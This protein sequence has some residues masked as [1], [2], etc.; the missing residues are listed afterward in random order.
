M[1]SLTR[2][3]WARWSHRTLRLGHQRPH[4]ALPYV[5][6]P[7][8]EKA[9]VTQWRMTP[10]SVF[11][12]AALGPQQPPTEPSSQPKPP[13]GGAVSS[14]CQPTASRREENKGSTA[15]PWAPSFP[16]L[17]EGKRVPCID[18]L[19]SPVSSALCSSLSSLFSFFLADIGRVSLC[20]SQIPLVTHY[21]VTCSFWPPERPPGPP[22]LTPP[23]P[24]SCMGLVGTAGT[25]HERVQRV[26]SPVLRCCPHPPCC[27]QP[28]SQV[29]S[30]PAV[31]RL[32]EARGEVGSG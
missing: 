18:P 31:R 24:P 30:R 20:Y 15:L 9:Q 7:H 1:T 21:F 3:G 14:H 19:L 2:R 6:T 22:G 25:R 29:T 10:A 27:L 4:R 32:G 5:E 17:E 11:S 26:Q 23:G 28:P 12:L 13:F 8:C 16:A